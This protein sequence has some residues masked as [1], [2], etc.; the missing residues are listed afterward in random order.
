[1]QW[2]EEFDLVAR[3]KIEG[4]FCSEIP[5]HAKELWL[6]NPLLLSKILEELK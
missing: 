4:K 2:K 1:M 5:E 3:K 6:C